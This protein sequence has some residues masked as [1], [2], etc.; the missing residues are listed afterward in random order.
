MRKATRDR[1]VL[2][3]L[4]PFGA[5][6]IIAIPVIGFSRILLSL[7]KDAATAIA[8]IVALSILVVAAVVA[9]R[10]VVR[11]SSL[12]SMLGAIAGVAMI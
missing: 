1:L 8:L 7:T 5:L 11:A 3:L 9:S 12:A 2:P 6:L 10:S 4:I